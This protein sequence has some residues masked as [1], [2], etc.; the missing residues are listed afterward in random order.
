VTRTYKGGDK[1]V[2]PQHGGVASSGAFSVLGTKV[3]GRRRRPGGARSA[4][5]SGAERRRRRG[6]QGRLKRAINEPVILALPSVLTLFAQHS[7]LCLMPIP[8]NHP[9]MS[10]V[11]FSLVSLKCLSSHH[12]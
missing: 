1:R 10:C 8:P 11:C 7:A 6:T 5:R 3:P 4:P 2:E 12:C 9:V